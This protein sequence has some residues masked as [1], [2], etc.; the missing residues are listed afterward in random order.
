MTW[1]NELVEELLGELKL[2]SLDGFLEESGDLL[3]S[4]LL[5][6]GCEI[7]ILISG[8]GF[9]GKGSLQILLGLSTSILVC[10][11]SFLL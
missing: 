2:D 8:H 9:A 7:G 10:H 4:F 3:I 6:H 11:F 5:C 1:D